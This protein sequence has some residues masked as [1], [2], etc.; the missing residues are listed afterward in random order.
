VQ[1]SRAAAVKLDCIVNWH[2]SNQISFEVSL[3]LK[4]L[5]YQTEFLLKMCL[6]MFKNKRRKRIFSSVDTLGQ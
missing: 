6:K 2:A 5:V 3:S 1:H 4:L